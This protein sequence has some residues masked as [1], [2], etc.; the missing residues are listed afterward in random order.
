M[1]PPTDDIEL[2]PETLEEEIE[3]GPL[4]HCDFCDADVVDKVAQ[5]FLPGLASACVDNTTGG[6]FKTPANVAVEIRK[7]MVENLVQ[8]SE[9]FVAESVV[10]EG[11]GDVEVSADSYDI[12]SD[13]VDDFVHSKRNFFSRVSGW[14][15]SEKREDWIDDLVQEM[16]INGFWL[17]NRRS[18]VAQ[19]LLKNLDFR[20]T[21]HCN[22]N[23]KSPGDLE[24]HKLSCG[25]RTLSCGNEGCDSSFS[26]AQMEH[27]DST[28]AFKMLSCEQKCADIIMRRE[29]DRHCITTCPMKLVKCPFQSVGCQSTV[30]QRTIEQHRSDN[31]PSRLLYILQVSHKGESLEALKQRVQELEKV[32]SPGRLA[33][34]RDAR[35]MAYVVKDLEAKLGPIKVHTEKKSD[36]DVKDLI[37]LREEKTNIEAKQV[38][39]DAEKE[40]IGISE[41]SRTPN[42]SFN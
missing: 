28:C 20:N 42:E 13:F 36:E 33:S 19:T 29:M 10:L 5:S 41:S 38:R 3:G 11:V 23:F 40:A 2:K 8:R 17:L 32:A 22:M 1:D 35:S 25:F 16:E 34:A 21:Y 24:K 30:P 9:N 14:I 7:E 37:D 12:I 6:L 15:L 4:F 27:H 18:T 26:A 39:F 31:I